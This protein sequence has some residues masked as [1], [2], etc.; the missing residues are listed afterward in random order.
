M[1]TGL[2]SKQQETPFLLPRLQPT[3][4]VT[5][6]MSPSI[7]LQYTHYAQSGGAIALALA[8]TKLP[9]G[10]AFNERQRNTIYFVVVAV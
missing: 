6:K 1:L 8:F 4:F 5:S 3:R 10:Q 2:R 7:R 9:S